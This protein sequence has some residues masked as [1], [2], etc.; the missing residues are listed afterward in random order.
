MYLSLQI[1]P[2][3]PADFPPPA[4]IAPT[5]AIRPPREGQEITEAVCP[6]CAGQKSLPRGDR[7]RRCEGSGNVSGVL[8]MRLT[9]PTPLPDALRQWLLETRARGHKIDATIPLAESGGGS[10]NT[11]RARII[12]GLNGEPL[13]S[14]GGSRTC[15]GE[16]ARFFI[17]AALIVRYSH[18]RGDGDGTVELVALSDDCMSIRQT[19]LYKFTD[20]TEPELLARENAGIAFPVEAVRAAK[21]KSRDYHCRSAYYAAGPAANGPSGALTGAGAAF[22]GYPS[23]LKGPGIGY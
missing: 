15:N 2:A 10:T 8:V 20:H 6:V 5:Y 11:G 14:F 7:C 19:E 17:K 12:C 9:T 22:G 23:P 1:I 21:Q 3:P 16:H 18:H 13:T 4:G